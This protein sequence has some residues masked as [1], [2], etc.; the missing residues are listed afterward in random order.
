VFSQGAYAA[1]G[2]PD[3]PNAADSIY[4]QSQGMTLLD[5]TPDGAGYNATFEIAIKTT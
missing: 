1:K 3:T 4:A 5:V 2:N